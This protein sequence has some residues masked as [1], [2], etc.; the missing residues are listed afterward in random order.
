[1]NDELTQSLLTA[2]E[3]KTYK[4]CLIY[5]YEG[6]FRLWDKVFVTLQDAKDY[7]DGSFKWIDESLNR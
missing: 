4:G 7:I 3:I 6:K 1:M 2:M 5:P